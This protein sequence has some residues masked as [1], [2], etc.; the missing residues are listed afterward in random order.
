MVNLAAP[1]E[2]R[3]KLK[4]NEKEDKYLDIVRNWKKTM[5]HK[6]DVYTNCNW[7][8]RYSHQGINKETGGLGNDST[9]GDH[10][11]YNII[12][13]YQNT[14]KS[15]GDLRILAV[16]KTPVKDSRE[17]PSALADVKKFSRSK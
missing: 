15:P 1:A 8:S 13:I 10:P 6:S 7:C 16:T 11:N 17:R 12:E 5:E 9:S 2:H 4:E 3:V 14:E